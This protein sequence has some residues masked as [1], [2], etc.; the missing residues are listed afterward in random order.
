VDI[1]T[2]VMQKV[3]S[4]FHEENL[5]KLARDTG[6]IRRIRKVTPEQFL[7]NMLLAHLDSP[8]S[9][10]EDLVYEFN[11]NNGY[12]ISKQ[13]LHKKI[14]QSAGV[15]MEKVLNE[16][17]SHGFASSTT[18]IG[19][20]PFVKNVSVIDSSEIRFHKKLENVFPQV[21][22]QGAAVKLQSLVEVVKNQVIALEI[23][24]SKE[25][26]QSYRNHL[27][28]IQTNDLLIGD[29]GYFCVESFEEI[30]NKDAFF[31]SRYFK[32]TS[33][34]DAKT[35]ELINLRARLNQTANE[36]IEFEIELGISKFPCRLV[37]VRLP[38]EAYCKR[39]QNLKKKRR[40]DPRA[41]E[42][43]EDVLNQWT[44]LVTNLPLSVEA[45]SLLHLYGLRW[46]IELFFKMAKTFMKLRKL[47]EMNQHNALI[48]LYTRLIAI[49]L[50]SMITMTIFDK[51]ISLYKASKLF[52]K[53][54]RRFI[55]FLGNQ[56][57]CAI[58]WFRELIEEFAL[59]ESC[60]KRPSTQLLLGWRPSYA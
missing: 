36:K 45:N 11:K 37:A 40:K 32:K 9:S 33:L 30:A 57:R 16:L 29:L 12:D 53:N 25:P 56:K 49:V 8:A 34:R 10:L 14:N 31:L 24:G 46:Q 20:I 58:F 44:I 48:S 5:I 19:T 54:S 41:K 18:C 35:K 55:E 3:N 4:V 50:L 1:L 22:N 38:E 60:I 21:R 17:L 13:A 42:T 2:K 51:E 39:L 47:N 23:C 26:D 7:K 52:I 6:F 43:D 15:F 28:Y 27:A 59:K